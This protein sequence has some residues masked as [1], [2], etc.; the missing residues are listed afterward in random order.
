MP[1]AK[2]TK[3]IQVKSDKPS[4]KFTENERR[5]IRKILPH[6]RAAVQTGSY[7]KIQMCLERSYMVW[8]D[9][10]PIYRGIDTPL[11]EWHAMQEERKRVSN[12][13]VMHN[14]LC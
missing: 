4:L 12:A 14:L 5:A 1:L 2:R 11:E 7:D 10:S 9:W 6:Y 3:K 13:R 8:F